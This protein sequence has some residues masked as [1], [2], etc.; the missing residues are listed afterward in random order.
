[1][2]PKAGGTVEAVRAMALAH[3]AHGHS[4]ETLCLDTPDAPWIVH[5]DYPFKVHTLGPKRYG[6]A[7]S[8]RLIP[9]LRENIHR[10]DL[11]IVHGLWL[12]PSFAVWW[13]LK[14]QPGLDISPPYL[15]MPHGMLDPWFQ[16]LDIR[17]LKAVRN[18]LYWKLIEH[19]VL[20]DAAAVLFTCEEEKRL[21]RNPF[22]PYQCR[23]K[24]IA[25]GTQE[26]PE[27]T[28]AMR[29][30]FLDHCPQLKNRPYLLFI[31][32]I[33]P[34]KGVDMLL[35]A[36]IEMS[37]KNTSAGKLPDLVIAGPVSDKRYRSKLNTVL[38]KAPAH[39]REQIH[40]PGMLSGDAKW[41]AYYGCEVFV[42]PSHQEN[43]GVAVVEALACGKSVLI[44]DKVN[45]WR[46]VQ[47]N[48]AGIVAD[49][50]RL[51]IFELLRNWH[52]LSE[53]QKHAMK[54]AARNCFNDRFS[55]TNTNLNVCENG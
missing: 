50:T 14:G 25:F 10:F 49:D 22:R 30:A 36:Y 3:Q 33:H 54:T 8:S 5:S 55:I 11:V 4:S 32:R 16:R 46:D 35:H 38:T 12:F 15:V 24:V 19:R 29:S 31:S 2:D 23:E 34:K 26:P 39:T 40:F 6:W 7:Y 43:F 37:M 42:L 45:I 41:G 1:M 13:I 44:T 17:P 53:T 51:G 18:A 47:A 27:F 9:W 52:A 48:R 21:A 20:R 28:P